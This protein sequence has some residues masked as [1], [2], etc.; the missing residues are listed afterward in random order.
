MRLPVWL[1]VLGVASAQEARE[2]RIFENLEYRFIGP[3]NMGGRATD[4]EGVP[5]DPDTVYAGFGGSGLWKTVNGGHSWTPLFEKQPVYSIGD[6]ALEPGNP[7]VVWVG[8]GESNTRNS[9]SFGNGI[10]QTTDGGKTWRH[11]GL[12][13]T[14]RISRLLIH[15]SN[16]RIVWAGV[17]GHAFGEHPDRGVFLTT[18]GGTSW[19]K[20]LYIDGQHGVADMDLHPTNP[21]IVYAA[22]WKFDRKPWTHTSGSEQGGVF[23]STDGG[24]SWSKL[25]KGLPK[26]LGRIGVKVAPSNPKVVYAIAESKEGTLYRSDDG[27][28]SFTEVTRNREIVSRGFY[29]SDLR[30]DPTNE[31]RLYA[32]AS[33]LFVSIDGGKTW[34]SIVNQTHI[35][36][37]ALWI[38]PRNP[39][40]MWNANDGGLATTNDRGTTW[41]SIANMAVG[42]FYQVHADMRQPFYWL[43]GGLQDNGSW[44]GPSRTREPGGIL[45]DDWRMV[46]FGDGFHML[47]HPDEPDVYLSESQGG[48]VARTDMRSREAQSVNPYPVNP[49]GGSAGEAKFR[50]NWNAPLIP[51]PHDNNTVYLG[52]N[53]LFRSRDFGRTWKAVSPDLT[54]ND[55]AKMK[56]AGGPIWFDNSTAEYHCTILSVAESP[57]AKDD[58]WA[59]TDDGRLHRSSNGGLDWKELTANIRDLPPNPVIT[60]VEPSRATVDVAYVSV[61]RHMFDDFRPYIFKTFDGGKNWAKIVD[62]LPANAYVHVVREDPKRT[63]VLYAGT[64]VGLYVSRDAGDNWFP[65]H[66][67]NLPAVAVHDIRVH[68]RENDLI[69]ATHGRS[70]VI[71]DDVAFLQTLDADADVQLIEPRRAMRLTTRMTRY[72]LGGSVFKG[73]NP[74]YGALLTY[75]LKRKPDEKETVKVE[76]L[77]STGNKIRELE[78]P[79]RAAGLNRIAWDLK[80]QPPT[81]RKPPSEFEEEVGRGPRGWEVLPGVYTVRLTAGSQTREQKLTVQMDPTMRV[82]DADLKRRQETAARLLTL[83]DS[84]NRT[85]KIVDSLGEQLTNAEKVVKIEGV[86][87]YHKALREIEASLARPADASRLELPPGLL[88]KTTGLFSLVEE[89]NASPTAAAMAAVAEVEPEFKKNLDAAARFFKETVP[90]W[91]EALRKAG[92]PTLVIPR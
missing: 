2:S 88:E 24:R 7:D 61:E 45:N 44:T 1:L 43:M 36:Y 59:G 29:Y 21:N 65:F 34:K 9:V 62:G 19:Q 87:E 79:P 3:A 18:D 85:L 25:E 39:K 40:H 22:M 69:L 32:V 5:G 63:Q 67:K 28:D 17:L 86:K 66:A 84:G 37:H 54:T 57:I 78:K 38:D 73:P 33:T 82:P 26:L 55:P 81:V 71:L 42:Q 35:D 8:T 77:D 70:F 27:G 53:L 16:P 64:E 12:A 20:T 4:V 80:S 89:A 74:P 92:A 11:M 47:N 68:A 15:P 49:A 72:G 31:N 52:G 75:F 60:H 13:E 76:I 6:L 10:Y 56:T 30:V 48:W 50:F 58:I 83:I 51:S 46:Q 41:H 14:E 23:R 91:N 90:Q